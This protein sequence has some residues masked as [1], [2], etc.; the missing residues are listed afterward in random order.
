MHS[1]SKTISS[2]DPWFIS[3]PS[4]TMTSRGDSLQHTTDRDNPS[5]K[6]ERQVGEGQDKL[7]IFLHLSTRFWVVFQ[8]KKKKQTEV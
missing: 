4:P 2:L 3:L 1:E 7:R 5:R 6:R 8:L